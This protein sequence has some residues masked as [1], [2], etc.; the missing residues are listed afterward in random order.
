[1]SIAGPA[2]ERVVYC[3]RCGSLDERR[4]YA[5]LRDGHVCSD[6]WH[7]LGQ[8]FPRTEADPELVHEVELRTRERMTAR[9]GPDKYLVRA[10]KS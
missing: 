10:G 8:P 3:H 4:M 5:P 7:T 1:M 9:G 2:V 6:C